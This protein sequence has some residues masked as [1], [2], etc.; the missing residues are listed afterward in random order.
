RQ[1]Q[2]REEN[3][4]ALRVLRFADDVAVMIVCDGAG[5]IG[6]GHEASQSAV[7]AISDALSARW[8]DTATLARADLDAAIEAAREAA[9]VEDLE[10]VTTA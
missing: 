6:G 3:Q 5:G 7:A 10:G 8:N 4:D 9:R 1:G 2:V